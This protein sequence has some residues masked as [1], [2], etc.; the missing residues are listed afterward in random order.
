MVDS[1]PAATLGLILLPALPNRFRFAHLF[2]GVLEIML[3]LLRF[4]AKLAC[5]VLVLAF[6]ASIGV[7]FLLANPQIK[8]FSQ[9]FHLSLKPPKMSPVGKSGTY[10]NEYKVYSI[11]KTKRLR[12][13]L[14]NSA[15]DTSPC[16]KPSVAI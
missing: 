14:E 15:V 1:L 4:L 9:L 12:D 2:N 11:Q 7:A 8:T 5:L 13:P 3:A 6:F 16:A 10:V